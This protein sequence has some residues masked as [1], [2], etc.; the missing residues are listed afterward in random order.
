MTQ[1]IDPEPTALTDPVMPEPPLPRDGKPCLVQIHPVEAALGTRYIVTDTPLLLGRELTCDIQICDRTVSRQHARIER[2]PD[3]H[4]LVDLQS[5]NGTFVNE[6]RVS[7]HRLKNGDSVSVGSAVFRFLSSS[8]VEAAYHQEIRRLAMLDPQTG[9]HNQ[10]FLLQMLERELHRSQRYGRPVALL[11]FDVDTF[12]TIN[13]AYGHLA[14]D[15]SL[16]ELV[17]C[18]QGILRREATFCRYGGDEF[19]VVLP[20][21][22]LEE[23]VLVAERIRAEVEQHPI[24]F[25]GAS[26]VLTVSVGVATAFGDEQMNA[27]HLIRLADRSLYEA[28]RQGRNRVIAPR[29][30]PASNS[31]A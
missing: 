21:T 30:D 10:R 13:D 12:K 29:V 25:D 14:G 28:K 7:T 22:A 17:V 4:W 31:C 8:N 5:T 3:G 18:V 11:L 27:D 2:E 15:Y 20:E 26:Y 9:I 1:E 24:H 16:R 19:A 23:S 6:E